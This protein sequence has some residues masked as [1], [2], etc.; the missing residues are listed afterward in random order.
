MLPLS[1]RANA[2]EKAF[3]PAAAQAD[4][5]AVTGRKNYVFR[6]V[7]AAQGLKHSVFQSH[8]P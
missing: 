7:Q 1:S 3:A 6:K 5:R 8:M 2:V 4:A